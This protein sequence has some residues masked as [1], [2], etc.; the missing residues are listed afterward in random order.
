MASSSDRHP[1]PN[2]TEPSLVDLKNAM[3]KKVDGAKYEYNTRKDTELELI[4]ETKEVVPGR[5]GLCLAMLYWAGEA[6]GVCGQRG[7]KKYGGRC[8][9]HDKTPVELK[10]GKK[11]VVAE[12]KKNGTKKTGGS[13]EIIREKPASPRTPPHVK[14][15][16][17]HK[18]Q[19]PRSPMEVA[20]VKKKF[21]KK[22]N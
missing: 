21:V 9:V 13:L 2:Y 11:A 16:K 5:E 4:G 14:K 6:R 8:K 17:S 15:R 12:K 3:K 18:S 7:C 20:Q 22:T 10:K 1:P 19:D